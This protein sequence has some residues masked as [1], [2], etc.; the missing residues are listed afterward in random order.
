MKKGLRSR[1][2]RVIPGRRASA[3][4]GIHNHRT[5]NGTRTERQRQ[6][7][8]YG[9][10]LATASRPGMTAE[11]PKVRRSASR[12]RRACPL[13]FDPPSPFGLWRTPSPYRGEGLPAEAQQGEG[14][15]AER[16]KAHQLC[17]CEAQRAFAKRARLAALHLR[18]SPPAGAAQADHF[19]RPGTARLI[20]GRAS[21]LLHQTSV[22]G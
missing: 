7:Y 4:T 18:L 6:D 16:R 2:H 21:R 8:G 1:S 20:S 19:V 10:R 9:F 11:K 22:T 14:G 3:G 13:H 12:G 17:A 5:R 15:G